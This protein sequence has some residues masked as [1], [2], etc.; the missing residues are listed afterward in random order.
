MD[1]IANML[2]SIKNGGLVKKT[3]VT[4]P[5]SKLKSAILE[6]LKEEGYGFIIPDIQIEASDKDVYFHV[7]AL[8]N[9]EIEWPEIKVGQKVKIGT[10]IV[11]RKGLQAENVELVRPNS[12]A[13]SAR[14]ERE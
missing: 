12:R 2:I 13:K 6:L 3:T 10:V 8:L 14:I 9:D 11:N 7:S 5:A 4:F 1:Q